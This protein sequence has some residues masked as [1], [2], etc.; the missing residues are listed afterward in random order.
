MHLSF[1]VLHF[2]FR[3]PNR[4]VSK[5]DVRAG[6][7]LGGASRGG[8]GSAAWAGFVQGTLLSPTVAHINKS[9][10]VPYQWNPILI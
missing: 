6:V 4:N 3:S 5:G 1:N 7:S 10:T 9:F 2:P 8:P